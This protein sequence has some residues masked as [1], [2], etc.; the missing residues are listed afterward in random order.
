MFISALIYEYVTYMG[1]FLLYAGILL[2]ATYSVYRNLPRRLNIAKIETTT[3]STPSATTTINKGSYTFFFKFFD[4]TL[5]LII[6]CIVSCTISHF[7]Y[8]LS[9]YLVRTL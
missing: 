8:T 3:V 6:L 4:I 9:S 7:E 5:I 1:I 2:I